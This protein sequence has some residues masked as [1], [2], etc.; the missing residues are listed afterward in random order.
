MAYKK[1]LNLDVDKTFALGGTNAKGDANPSSVEGYYLGSRKCTTD[2]GDAELHIFQTG[3]DRVGVWGKT[4]LNKQL[5]AVTVGAMVLAEFT[6]MGKPQK[7]RR[8]PYLYSVQYDPDNTIDVGAIAA[9]SSYD[10]EDDGCEDADPETDVAPQDEVP[11]Q[12]AQAP[13]QAARPNAQT[14]RDLLSSR[15]SR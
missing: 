3:D 15:K 4:N 14:T 2:Y 9:T 1:V 11:P 8:P 13:R 12:R 5:A 10:D 6:G 7:G